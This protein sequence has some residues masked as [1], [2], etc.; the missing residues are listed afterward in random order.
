MHSIEHYEK[1]HNSIYPNNLIKVLYRE[2]H[3]VYFET[4][5]GVCKKLASCI[6]K[7]GYK[8]ESSINKT[9][10]FINKANKIHNNKYYYTNTQFINSKSKIKIICPEHGEFLQKANH[11]ISGHGCQKCAT[12]LGHKKINITRSNWTLK[13]WIESSKKSKGFSGFKCYIIK[14]W[15]EDEEFYKIGR[16]FQDINRRFHSKYSMPYNYEILK[17][18]ENTPKIIYSLEIALK[19]KNKYNKYTPK[20]NFGGKD[21]CY[22]KVNE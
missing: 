10:Y 4:E 3:Y 15:N 14:C 13:G 12:I 20:I 16:T 5:F 7:T 11:H 1:L 6:G 22:I 21:E 18:Y 9:E 19:R 2:K 8:L 17:V